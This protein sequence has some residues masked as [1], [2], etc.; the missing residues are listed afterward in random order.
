MAGIEV[1]L[2]Y[3]HEGKVETFPEAGGWIVTEE[4]TLVIANDLG[5]GKH[6]KIKEYNED[7][8]FSVGDMKEGSSSE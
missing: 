3:P 1:L 5:D 7:A 2:K 4:R 8:W 6:E